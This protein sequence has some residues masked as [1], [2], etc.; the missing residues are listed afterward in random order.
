[1][2]AA[3]NVRLDGLDQKARSE[4]GGNL[5]LVLEAMHLCNALSDLVHALVII[6]SVRIDKRPRLSGIPQTKGRGAASWHAF[7][8]C[9][10]FLM[11]GF[12]SVDKVPGR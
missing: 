8:N 10:H 1:M 5:P 11:A 9:M 3:D 2:H 7:P 12:V 6:T 4:A